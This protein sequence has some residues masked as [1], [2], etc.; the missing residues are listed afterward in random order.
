MVCICIYGLGG[1]L[2]PVRAG[3][4]YSRMGILENESVIAR[5][6]IS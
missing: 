6:H 2:A 4:T 5:T 1:G 3:S